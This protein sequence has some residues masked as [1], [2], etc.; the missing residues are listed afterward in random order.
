MSKHLL[1][2]D[3]T[4]LS[5]WFDGRVRIYRNVPQRNTRDRRG[6]EGMDLEAAGDP[7][8]GGHRNLRSRLRDPSRLPTALERKLLQVGHL[9]ISSIRKRIQNKNKI[10]WIPNFQKKLLGAAL[11]L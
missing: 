6:L 3:D 1:R 4:E 9:F 8:T 7:E 10:F 11:E 5:I 2:H